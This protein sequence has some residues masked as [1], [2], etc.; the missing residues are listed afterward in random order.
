MRGAWV[1]GAVLAACSFE[2][3]ALPVGDG[4]MHPGSDGSMIDVPPMVWNAPVDMGLSSGYGDDDPSLTD[5]L[6]EIYWGSR[7]PGGQGFED[8]WFATRTSSTGDWSAAA[9][10]VEL[11][12]SAT[13]TTGKITGDG[14]SIFFTSTRG[15]GS[16]PDIYF[17]SRAN[18]SATWSTPVKVSELSVMNNG[19]YGPHAQSN[20]LHVIWCAGASVPFEALWTSNRASTGDAWG[21]PAKV[22]ELDETN[23]SECD[24]MEPHPRAMYYASNRLSTTAR[25]DIYRVSRATVTDPYGSRT[26]VEGVN[27]VDFNDRDPWV[28]ADERTMIFSSDRDG[29]IDK[30]YMTTR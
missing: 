19:D 1:V 26:A 30:L 5:D 24:P 13:E 29:G 4:S 18:R 20:L 28:S 9:P 23:T 10:A 12:T 27:T 15:P 7:R 6:L 2:H 14:L 17:S 25:Y 16:D 3:G 22:S 11:N 21:T 8:I